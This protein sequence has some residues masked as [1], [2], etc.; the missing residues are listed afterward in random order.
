MKKIVI[1][2]IYVVLS[3][4]FC[5]AQKLDTDRISK[6]WDSIKEYIL[7]EYCEQY[8][9]LYKD[10]PSQ[11]VQERIK[12][13]RAQGFEQYTIGQWKQQIG[14]IK[15]N[16]KDLDN[17]VQSKLDSFDKIDVANQ[18]IKERIENLKTQY[19]KGLSESD[20]IVSK[21]DFANLKNDTTKLRSSIK[22]LE[23][24]LKKIDSEIKSFNEG[25]SSW[26]ANNWDWLSCVVVILFLV[27]VIVKLKSS[28]KRNRDKYLEQIETLKWDFQ[29]QLNKSRRAEANSVS[30]ETPKA[31]KVS[32]TKEER[33]VSVQEAKTVKSI[34]KYLCCL[35]YE[36]TFERVDDVFDEYDSC[37]KFIDIE[38]ADDIYSSKE[39]KFVFY[40][41][42]HSRAI[43][44][45]SSMLK[46][47]SNY[48]GN[49][50]TAKTVNNVEPGIVKYDSANERWKIVKKAKLKLS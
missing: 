21:K 33:V 13:Y 30:K 36:G 47:A 8:C 10:D 38:S 22:K 43:A 24:D 41:T 28:M 26:L 50:E 46:T 49:R 9:V 31:P 12:G 5:L 23:E 39:L 44:N 37:Y 2:I 1:L 19:L 16:N 32:V 11:I 42:D 29:D 48:D 27:W 7:K 34:N 14:G 45:W 40:S 3:F 15:F 35:T 4:N 18:H 25:R 20:T 17:L 6:E